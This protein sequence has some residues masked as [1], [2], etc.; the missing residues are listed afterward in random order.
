[1]PK[2]YNINK[3]AL[4]EMSLGNKKLA[5]KIEMVGLVAVCATLGMVVASGLDGVF[6]GY[7]LPVLVGMAA[8]SIF[9]VR[10]VEL[11]RRYTPLIFDDKSRVPNRLTSSTYVII[12]NAV[13]MS[14]Y[15]LAFQFFRWVFL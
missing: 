2:S 15:V 4:D 14:S 3:A 9:I 5:S 10:H 8:C 1:M 11:L 13:R 12:V 7:L 6:F